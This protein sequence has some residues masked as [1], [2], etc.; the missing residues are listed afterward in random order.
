MAVQ[1]ATRE[2]L[3]R[4]IDIPLKKLLY[5]LYSQDRSRYYTEKE[6]AKSSG[7]VRKLH[8]VH[9]A[10]KGVQRKVLDKLQAEFKPTNHSH[11]FTQSRSIISNAIPHRRKKII[12]KVDLSD[13][14][15]TIK[16][17]RVKGMFGAP[18][19][20]FGDEACTTLAQICCLSD[21]N[22]QLPQG[23]VTSP[24]VANMM[25]RRLDSRMAGI[26][27][28]FRC[29]FT[30]YADDITFSTNDV[31]KLDIKKLLGQIYQTIEEEGFVPNKEKTKILTPKDRQIVTGIVVNDGINVNRRYLRNI[32]ATIRNIEKYGID[33]QI[34]KP[35]YSSHKSYKNKSSSRPDIQKLEGGYLFRGSPKTTEEAALHFLRHVVGQLAFVGQVVTASGQGNQS[36]QYPRIGAYKR[37]LLRFYESVRKDGRFDLVEKMLKK[38]MNK[39]ESFLQET[40]WYQKR[41]EMHENALS[42]FR[43]K[44]ETK[45]DIEKVNAINSS[46]ELLKFV[47]S[48]FNKDP[49]YLISMPLELEEARNKILD[50]VNYPPLSIKR[51]FHVLEGLRHT[52]QLGA[53][54]H[55]SGNTSTSKYLEIL[56][57]DFERYYYEVPFQLR[58]Y[59]D[60]VSK[61]LRNVIVQESEGYLLHILEDPRTEDVVKQLKRDTRLRAQ[62]EDYS[63]G[64]YIKSLLNDVIEKARTTSENSKVEIDIKNVRGATVYTVVPLV[65]QALIDIV[66]SMLKNTKSDRIKISSYYTDDQSGCYVIEVSDKSDAVIKTQPGRAFVNGKLL[67]AITKLDGVSGYWVTARFADGKASCVDM[68]KRNTVECNLDDSVGVVHHL[69]FPTIDTPSPLHPEQFYFRDAAE[70]VGKFPGQISTQK[71]TILILDNNLARLKQSEQAMGENNHIKIDARAEIGEHDFMHG[72]YVMALVHKSND[73]SDKIYEHWAPHSFPVVFF[74]GG[75]TGELR[76]TEQGKYWHTSAKYLEDNILEIVNKVMKNARLS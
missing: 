68:L 22:G 53:I 19:F 43:S 30:R 55:D 10:L 45:K 33:S 26:A 61:A 20:S 7:A 42:R 8:A 32:R 31:N 54:T 2:D 74:S 6:I 13:F 60:K 57:Q 4:Y 49:R 71:E 40:I 39:H 14:F 27:R 67:R 50:I 17:A 70:K 18:P 15:P 9:G 73:E 23:G 59:F 29:H 51:T 3:A 41:T 16:F 24:F 72:G 63:G 25:C 56:L 46:E 65:K 76:N 64:T 75:T 1:I 44:S 66:V 69:V 52:A 21:A 37:L 5:I 28:V 48:K 38:Q 36:E 47:R 11:G 12:V 35:P 58:K 62:K 34:V